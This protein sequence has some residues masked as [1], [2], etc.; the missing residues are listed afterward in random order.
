MASIN[1]VH[2]GQS[3]LIWSIC[4]LIMVLSQRL[5]SCGYSGEPA[6]LG[7]PLPSSPNSGT[8][9]SAISRVCIKRC[10]KHSG[11][12]TLLLLKNVLAAGWKS[13][14]R[15]NP[16]FAICLLSRMRSPHGNT[17]GKSSRTAISNENLSIRYYS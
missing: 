7:S 15:K 2:F 6:T 4:L 14:K 17:T 3:W 11:F 10:V 8:E 16:N 9:L 5:N 1:V 13:G 12:I